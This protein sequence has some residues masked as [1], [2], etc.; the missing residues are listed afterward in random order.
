MEKGPDKSKPKKVLSTPKDG[1]AER[2]TEQPKGRS[3]YVKSI[4]SPKSKSAENSLPENKVVKKLG[5]PAKDGPY[6]NKDGTMDGSSE[7]GI[8]ISS[9]NES[10]LIN[11]EANVV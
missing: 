9:K 5:S 7:P 4:N 2:N 10:A 1:L 11:G 3:V 8:S 6:I